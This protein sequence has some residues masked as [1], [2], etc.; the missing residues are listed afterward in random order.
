M[1]NT[2]VYRLYVQ[3]KRRK[4]RERFLINKYGND[5]KIRRKAL[6]A[7]LICGIAP[8]EFHRLHCEEKTKKEIRSFLS[9]SE[10][11]EFYRKYNS[12][13]AQKILSDKYMA[14]TR[15][16][17][18]YKRDCM[19]I[20]K[21]E[22]ASNVVESKIHEFW[23]KDSVNQRGVIFKPLKGERGFGISIY[24]D[25]KEAVEMI[26]QTEGGVVEELIVQ[27]EELAAYNPSSVN[28]LRIITV[29]YGD[30]V[31]DVKWPV[32]R[33]GR[34]GSVVDNSGSG[35]VFAAVDVASGKTIAAC[36]EFHNFFEVHPDTKKQLR[37]VVIPKW[38]EACAL[39]KHLATL[40]PEAVIVGWDLALSE[41]GWC[42]VEGNSSPLIGHQIAIDRGLKEEWRKTV[43]RVRR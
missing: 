41:D 32:M 1:K 25:E 6:W 28:T 10:T 21:D 16:K 42:M 36:D 35:G 17:D 15:F 14:Y 2:F 18:Y 22:I 39:A 7:W 20:T 9:L 19:L 33:Y 8:N 34:E 4:S 37:G 30:G 27:T 38:D 40:I 26:K 29:N 43:S 12:S 23:K 24:R 5:R 13:K 3:L 31:V 11:R